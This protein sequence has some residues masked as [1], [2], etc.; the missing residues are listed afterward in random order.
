MQRVATRFIAFFNNLWFRKEKP[1]TLGVF[2]ILFGMFLLLQ[3]L[4]NFPNWERLFGPDAIVPLSTQGQN[5]WNTYLSIFSY[6]NYTTL[7]L[8]FCLAVTSSVAFTFGIW[9]RTSTFILYIIMDSCKL[10]DPWVMEGGEH[11]GIVVL[12]V[13]L[14]SPIGESYSLDTYRKSRKH[15]EL[16]PEGKPST[17]WSLWL[18]RVFLTLMYGSS[19]FHKLTESD[20]WR[21]GKALYNILLWEQHS[22]LISI[23][24][25]HNPLLTTAL[26]YYTIVIEALTPIL[27]WVPFLRPWLALSLAGLHAG[28][29]VM[30]TS[31]TELFNLLMIIMTVLLIDNS[32]MG[33][34]LNHASIKKTWARLKTF[35]SI[36]RRP[37]KKGR[38]KTGRAKTAPSSKTAPSTNAADL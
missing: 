31:A 24:L 19:I 33:K 28:I 7:W 13:L 35:K 16:W 23:E 34:W 30:L 36:E 37:A 15:P 5:F 14:L 9:T 26:T 17:V 3:F 4:T 22:R 25:I 2:R 12:F 38:S 10:R 27:I 21:S 1:L 8:V 29:M 18:L 20:H 32:L 11:V 6:C